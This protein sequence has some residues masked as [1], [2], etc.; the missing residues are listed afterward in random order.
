MVI[1]NTANYNSK[2]VSDYLSGL[3]KLYYIGQREN[4][5]YRE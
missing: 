3:C 2:P 1:I 5:E 4:A